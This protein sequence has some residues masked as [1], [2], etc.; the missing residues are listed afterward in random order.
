MELLDPSHVA[1]GPLEI[2]ARVQQSRGPLLPDQDTVQ[3]RALAV[4][5][6][7]AHAGR[8][9]NVLV[10]EQQQRVELGLSESAADLLD[11]LLAQLGEIAAIFVVGSELPVSEPAQIPSWSS[12]VE[13]HLS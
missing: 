7:T 8:V 5:D 6:L 13:L 10:L 1:L 3:Q 11:A 4:E 9:A 2:P 12:S